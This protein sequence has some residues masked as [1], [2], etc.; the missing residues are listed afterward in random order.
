MFSGSPH[1]FLC[2]AFLK[3]FF[4]DFPLPGSAPYLYHPASVLFFL[5]PAIGSYCS[6]GIEKSGGSPSCASNPG[7]IPQTNLKASSIRG[8]V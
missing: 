3:S 7:A 1:P 2:Q 8:K 5:C 4:H 6:G